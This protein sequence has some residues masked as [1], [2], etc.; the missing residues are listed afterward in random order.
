MALDI[1][2]QLDWFFKK[3]LFIWLPVAVI[4]IIIKEW[5]GKRKKGE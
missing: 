1:N 4:V 2:K 5:V 3:I